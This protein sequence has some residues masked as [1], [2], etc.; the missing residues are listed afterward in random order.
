MII[1]KP[2]R[3]MKITTDSNGNEYCDVVDYVIWWFLGIIPLYI[4]VMDK[5]TTINHGE[6][7]HEGAYYWM[8]NNNRIQQE[9]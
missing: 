9:S 1:K 5:Y 6:A 2:Y 7:M 4:V 8:K 3:K